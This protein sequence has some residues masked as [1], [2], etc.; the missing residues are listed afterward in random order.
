MEIICPN[1]TKDHVSN[2][3]V[4]TPSHAII[5]DGNDG[6]E[7]VKA[8]E[9]YEEKVERVSHLLSGKK[10][11]GETITQDTETPNESLKGK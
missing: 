8:G 9:D 4:P 3:I 5:K 2:I 10:A 1:F 6:E 7:N 11:D